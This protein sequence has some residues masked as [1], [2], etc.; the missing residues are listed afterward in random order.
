VFSNLQDILQVLRRDHKAELV[1]ISNRPEA[2]SLANC[3]IPIP[4]SIPEWLSPIISIIPGQLFAYHLTLA[5]GYDS[6]NPRSIHKITE[7]H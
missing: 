6:E 5:K 4:N 1:V 7:T 3:A 2:L